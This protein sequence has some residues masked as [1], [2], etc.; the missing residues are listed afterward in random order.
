VLTGSIVLRGSEVI[1]GHFLFA[2]SK[3]GLVTVVQAEAA[4]GVLVGKLG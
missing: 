3:L 2:N 4:A 1:V